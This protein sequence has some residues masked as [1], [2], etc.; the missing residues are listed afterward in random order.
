MRPALRQLLVGL[1][2]LRERVAPRDRKLDAAVGDERRHLRQRLGRRDRV[3]ALALD[4]QPL[5]GAEVG[6]RVD[7]IDRDAELDREVNVTASER[8]NEGVDVT[9][10]RRAN[11]LRLPLAVADGHRTAPAEPGVVAFARKS[12]RRGPGEHHQLH[13][14]RAD[15]A[16]RAGDDDD[17]A[18]LRGDGV[19]ARVGSH[20][21]DEERT[22]NLPRELGGLRGQPRRGHGDELGVACPTLRPAAHR[23]PDRERGD[24]LAELLDHAREIGPLAGGEGRRPAAMEQA[25]A[26]GDLARVDRGRL[27][28]DEHLSGTRDRAIDLPDLQHLDPA[29]VIESD[30]LHSS[31]RDVDGRRGRRPRAETN[32]RD[33]PA[34]DPRARGPR[35]QSTSRRAA[36]AAPMPASATAHATRTIPPSAGETR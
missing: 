21:D 29:V 36:T 5:H 9:A 26:N 23:V 27:H 6:D 12:D 28:G 15:P 32:Q 30:C 1:A 18:R 4:A 11:A 24:S 17:L 33:G 14:E 13:R 25:L 7:P 10:R 35:R 22:G 19:D 3:G 16:G 20:R 8:V 34:L 2:H 31:P